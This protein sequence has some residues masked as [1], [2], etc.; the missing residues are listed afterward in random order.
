MAYHGCSLPLSV[1][2]RSS[3]ALGTTIESLAVRTLIRQ[4]TLHRGSTT[5]TL[6]MLHAAPMESLAVLQILG[7]LKTTEENSPDKLATTHIGS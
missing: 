1:F 2:N 5:Y 7:R 4:A 6:D 3:L